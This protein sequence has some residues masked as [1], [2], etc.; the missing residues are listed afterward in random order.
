MQSVVRGMLLKEDGYKYVDS[1]YAISRNGHRPGSIISTAGKPQESKQVKRSERVLRAFWEENKEKTR[2]DLIRILTEESSHSSEEIEAWVNYHFARVIMNVVGD[3]VFR[4][5]DPPPPANTRALYDSSKRV[6][7]VRAS[8]VPEALDVANNGTT[9]TINGS[10]LPKAMTDNML[11]SFYAK[12][13]HEWI[14][15][16]SL[17]RYVMSITAP[18]AYHETKEANALKNATSYDEFLRLAK[19]AA[20]REGGPDMK[21]VSASLG[22]QGDL[23]GNGNRGTWVNEATTEYLN[24][25]RAHFK[26]TRPAYRQEIARQTR[27]VG[28]GIPR[29]VFVDGMLGNLGRPMPEAHIPWTYVQHEVDSRLGPGTWSSM[30]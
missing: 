10:P 7:A 30:N 23:Q 22:L 1:I 4:T 19:A 11:R 26:G 9:L 27:L 16:V 20:S 24:W 8:E 18:P 17:S 5:L 28:R 6:I 29:R 21:I 12:L 14:H 15:A 3:S 25:N 13:F 2:K